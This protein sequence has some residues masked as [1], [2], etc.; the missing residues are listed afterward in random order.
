[1]SGWAL[2]NVHTHMWYSSVF[3]VV[4]PAGLCSV[5]PSLDKLSLWEISLKSKYVSGPRVEVGVDFGSVEMG[6]S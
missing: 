2:V 3:S 6:F 5:L 1:M 4:Q